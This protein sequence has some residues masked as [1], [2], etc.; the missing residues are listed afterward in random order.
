VTA[1]MPF[2][3]QPTP[4]QEYTISKCRLIVLPISIFFGLLNERNSQKR[5]NFAKV[6]QFHHILVVSA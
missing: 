5:S 2:I 4:N 3:Y 1:T 6:G